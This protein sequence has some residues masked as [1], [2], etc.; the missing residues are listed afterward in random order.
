MNHINS[1]L[2]INSF[3]LFS[4]KNYNYPSLLM[5]KEGDLHQSFKSKFQNK[6][7]II[8]FPVKL[9]AEKFSTKD[10]YKINSLGD[11]KIH[12]ENIWVPDFLL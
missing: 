2:Y 5:I 3:L 10:S 9:T 11:E 8:W 6:N 1:P 7:D 4:K 12:W